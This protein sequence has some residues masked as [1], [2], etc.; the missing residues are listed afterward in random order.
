MRR[1]K[2][3]RENVIEGDDQI[4]SNRSSSFGQRLLLI[5]IKNQLRSERN[6][7]VIV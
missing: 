5:I 1:K 4:E 2:D 6:I 3:K 7:L